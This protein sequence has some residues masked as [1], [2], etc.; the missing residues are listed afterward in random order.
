VSPFDPADPDLGPAL[1]RLREDR[2]L[3]QEAVAHVAGISTGT[4]SR[5]ETGETNPSWSTVRRV[6]KALGVTMVEVG[7]A[8]E[9]G[10]R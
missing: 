6:A 8:V 9:G 10:L 7:A 5:T 1:K 4:L 2:G 3:K